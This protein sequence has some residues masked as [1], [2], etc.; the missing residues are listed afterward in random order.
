PANYLVVGGRQIGKS[1]LLK[2]IE[3]RYR[4][5]PEINCYYVVLFD[6]D[7]VG[8]LARAVGLPRDT[9]PGDLFAYLDN[10]QRRFFLIDEADA[11]IRAERRNNHVLLSRLRS[12]SEQGRGHFILAGFWDLY[13]AAVHDYH[14]PLKNFGEIQVVGALEPDACRELATVPMEMMGLRY[15]TEGLVDRMIHETGRR[16]KLISL[17]CNE[18]VEQHQLGR[19]EV[20]A[21]SVKAVLASRRIEEALGG[22]NRLSDDEDSNRLDRILVWATISRDSFTQPEALRTLEGVGGSASPEEVSR[23][24]ERLELAFVLK[25]EETRYTYR[26]PLFQRMLMKQD[27]SFQ[28]ARELERFHS[29]QP[30]PR[31]SDLPAQRMGNSDV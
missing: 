31:E 12:L 28:L 20:G 22:W 30:L 23:S 7:L 25:R 15:T 17:A 11:F 5:H 13:I 19:R 6:S 27:P 26:V 16:A 24:L 9:P 1:S 21:D 2:A 3:R 4:D 18:L 29:G 10:G 8:P 14:S